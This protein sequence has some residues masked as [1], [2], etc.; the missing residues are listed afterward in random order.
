MWIQLNLLVSFPLQAPYSCEQHNRGLLYGPDGHSC[1]C[2]QKRSSVMA[3]VLAPS[4]PFL[5]SAGTQ[6]WA[7]PAQ[8]ALSPLPG[9]LPSAAGLRVLPHPCDF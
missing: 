3:A 6:L 4:L 5:L 9:A 1:S 8:L 7:H 2:G